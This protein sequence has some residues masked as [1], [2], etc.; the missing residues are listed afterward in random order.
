MGTRSQ[1]FTFPNRA[2]KKLAGR[3]ELPAGEPKAFVLFAHCF[4]CSK[5]IAAAGRI[6]RGLAQR[7]FGVLRFDFTG[8]GGSQGDFSNTD[9]SSNVEDLVDAASHLREEFAAPELLVGHSLGGAAS[10]IAAKEIPEVGSV[11]TIG[12]PSDPKHVRQLLQAEIP[13]I[14]ERGEALVRLAGRE[15]RIKRRF[16]EDLEEQSIGRCLAAFKGALLIFH[17][18]QDRI[19]GVD[20][21][22]KIYEAASHPKSFISLDRADHLLSQ[23]EDAEFVASV[24]SAWASRYVNKAGVSARASDRSRSATGPR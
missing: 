17:S 1:K 21:A 18:P 24:L 19:V 8:L 3:L 13:E 20:N 22:R 11:A 2:G 14:E 4:T 9:F 16:L 5:D 12:A 23:K 15:F 6:S 10:I 7:G